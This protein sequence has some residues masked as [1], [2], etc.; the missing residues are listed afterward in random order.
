MA[1]TFN[2]A[3]NLVMDKLGYVV[4]CWNPEIGDYDSGDPVSWIWGRNKPPDSLVVAKSNDL[5]HEW[6]E[7]AKLLTQAGV[8]VPKIPRGWRRSKVVRYAS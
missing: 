5:N 4:I 1:A 8:K 3:Y 7:Q 2:E 6:R